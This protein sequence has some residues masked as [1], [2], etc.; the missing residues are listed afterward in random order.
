MNAIITF[1]S[2]VNQI[3]RVPLQ[4]PSGGSIFLGRIMGPFRFKINLRG[5]KPTHDKPFKKSSYS[6]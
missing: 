2:S 1:E 6:A 3:I 5:R 4:R